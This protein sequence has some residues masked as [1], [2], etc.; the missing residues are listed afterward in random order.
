MNGHLI[1][2]KTSRYYQRYIFCRMYRF[3]RPSF[4][5]QQSYREIKWLI[6]YKLYCKKYIG[7]A[8]IQHTIPEVRETKDNRN[9]TTITYKNCPIIYGLVLAIS[10]FPKIESSCDVKAESLNFINILEIFKRYDMD[11]DI[12]CISNL[13]PEQRRIGGD[14]QGCIL[15]H[16]VDF[17]QLGP[18]KYERSGSKYTKEPGSGQGVEKGEI[19]L[20][21]SSWSVPNNFVICHLGWQIVSAH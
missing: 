6:V 1:W 15:F 4:Y 2:L 11:W 8:R 16:C 18:V 17:H 20:Q 13:Q 7:I 21:R 5:W 19:V 9:G 10:H 3:W 12:I 14:R